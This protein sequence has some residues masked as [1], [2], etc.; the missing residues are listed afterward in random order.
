MY[1]IEDETNLD[2]VVWKSVESKLKKDQNIA[3][4]SL[5]LCKQ[6]KTIT[7]ESGYNDGQ[8]TGDITKY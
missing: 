6:F 3:N 4:T 5:I 2:I 8:G 7:V 1:D